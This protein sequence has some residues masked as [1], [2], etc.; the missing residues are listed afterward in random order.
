MLFEVTNSN[1][2]KEITDFE[3]LIDKYQSLSYK[4]KWLYYN[5][6]VWERVFKIRL[7]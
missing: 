6:A 5:I 4:D 1:L 3:K 2:L 7:R